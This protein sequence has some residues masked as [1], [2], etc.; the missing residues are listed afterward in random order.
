[1]IARKCTLQDLEKALELTNAQYDSNVEWNRHPNTGGF[2]LKV[3]DSKGKG[4]RRGFSG[5]RLINACW[6]VHG[7]FFDNLFEVVPEASVRSRGQVITKE[8]GNWEDDNIGSKM[9]PLYFS[10]ACDCGCTE[11]GVLG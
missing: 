8:F 11:E 9:S 3:K 1:M 7:D 4:A 6:H 10:E 2:T 5:R